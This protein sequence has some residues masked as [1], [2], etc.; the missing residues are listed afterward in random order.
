MTLTDTIVRTAS[1]G[2]VAAVGNTWASFT[3]GSDIEGH[4]LRNQTITTPIEKISGNNY[5][6]ASGWS[7]ER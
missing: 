4:Y 7:L 5:A 6:I 1:T 3:Q 2:V